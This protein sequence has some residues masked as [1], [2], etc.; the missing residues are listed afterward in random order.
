[1]SD[2]LLDL[3]RKY[4]GYDTL[5]PIQREAM[6][7]MLAGRDSLIVLPTGGGKSL[8]Y[9]APALLREGLTVVVSPL[10]ALMKDQV[11][12]L[13]ACGIEADQINSGQDL[14]EK[15]RIARDVRS[16]KTRLLFVSP[17]RLAVPSFRDFLAK[18]NVT[19]FAI[20][21]A[22]CI[23]HWGHDF[24]PEYRALS[25][26]HEL[27]PAASLHAF[28]ATATAR[29]RSDIAQQLALRDPVIK[30]GNFDRPN[31]TYRVVPRV[32][33]LPQVEEVLARH[34]GNAGIIY[35]LRR[36]D[37]D[38]LAATLQERGYKAVGYHAGMTGDERH[39]AQEEFSSERCDVV[40]ATVAFGMGIDRSNVRFV[41]HTGMPKS[42]EH[43]QQEAGR[44]G[45][46][47]LPAECILLYSGADAQFWRT[48]LDRGDE[49][50]ERDEAFIAASLRHIA[51]IQRYATAPVC[52]HQS[53]V[54]Y[55][56]ERWEKSSCGA[57][58]VCLEPK[59]VLEDSE[60][61][62]QK[63]LSCIVRVRE[64]FG[65]LH[66]IDVLLGHRTDKV[67]ER[68]HNE[69]TTFGLMRDS[70]K[71]ELRS[72]IDQL[73]AAGCIGL[74]GVQ[75]P[76]LFV[77][78]RG[79]AL[80]RGELEVPLAVP[81][82]MPRRPDTRKSAAIA[83][84]SGVDSELFEKLRAWRRETAKERGVPPFVIFDDRTLREIAARKPKTRGEL[85]RVHGVGDVKLEAFADDVLGIVG[86]G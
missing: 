71:E 26:L 48:L 50:G 66:V 18:V 38:A 7:A 35:C 10:I 69:L 79:R 75:Y 77:T 59:A 84:L 51:D 30:V 32:K 53:L 44:A 39:E 17:E 62:A 81:R 19:A 86:G 11:D 49:M 12:A 21:E 23:S 61:V 63:I 64:S 15:K 40:V 1:M 2:P 55:F 47:G 16:G 46:D 85:R 70:S 41:L 9:Q 37:V 67:T 25:S 5:R 73:I 45:R 78:E 28:T 36:R 76:T 72:F 56:G 80:L 27:F 74:S 14:D 83:P 54:E 31:L 13:H 65:A 24:R 60:V 58:D 3:V 42:I 57:C 43:Y 20:D 68:R 34:K 29:V 82:A 4:W 6:E 8:C 22:H 33:L 52:R